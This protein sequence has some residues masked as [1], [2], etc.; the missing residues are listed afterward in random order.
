MKACTCQGKGKDRRVECM[1]EKN[2]DVAQ[3]K[4][5]AQGGNHKADREDIVNT[6]EIEDNY[7]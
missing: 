7:K 3:G 2:L 6:G 5:E 4:N 1:S